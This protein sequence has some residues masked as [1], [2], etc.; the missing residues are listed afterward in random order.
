[1]PSAADL[2]LANRLA[3]AAGEAIRPLFRGDWA[4]ERKSDATF[5]TEADRAAEAAM[6][7]I[8]ES[9]RPDDGIIG[10]EYGNRNPGAGR[11]WV[12]DPID[13]T[14][15][16]IAGRP[17][18]GTLIALME[19]GWPVIGL[20]DQPILRERW[21]ALVGAGTTFNGQ[22]ART[23]PCPD[24]SNAVLGTTSP[25]CFSGEQVDG[26]MG[27]AGK[28]AERKIVYGGDCYSYGLVASGHMDIVCEAGLKLHDFAALIPV[29][30]GA[31]GTMCD[32]QGE[33]LNADSGGEVIA[34][35]DPARLE[36]VI[37]AMAGH[38]HG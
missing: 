17:I 23:A 2:A 8:I 18:F 4:E 5:V 26:F 31:G 9:E 11:Q 16:F 13:G 29:V 25:H 32:W 22:P 21:A 20:I 30:E 35:G 34:L 15:S 36:D 12:L 14:T 7:A 3:D 33:P 10:E 19:G 1:M 37:E 27:L 6:R 38:D 24:L 28:V